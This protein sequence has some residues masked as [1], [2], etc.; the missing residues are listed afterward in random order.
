MKK[1][2]R[3]E[4][5]RCENTLETSGEDAKTTL[6]TSVFFSYSTLQLLNARDL[7]MATVGSS[8]LEEIPGNLR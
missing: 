3:N 4:W 5:K 7:Y 6:V 2:T 1:D 8:W